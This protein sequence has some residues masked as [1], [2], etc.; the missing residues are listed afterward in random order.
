MWKLQ[1]SVLLYNAQNELENISCV[2][3]VSSCAFE[4]YLQE[5]QTHAGLQGSHLVNRQFCMRKKQTDTQILLGLASS[6]LR[7][8]IVKFELS[9]SCPG[10]SRLWAGLGHTWVAGVCD[11]T[12]G[13]PSRAPGPH[14]PLLVPPS[15]GSSQPVLSQDSDSVCG[16]PRNVV[17]L[18]GSRRQG[19]QTKG[20]IKLPLGSDI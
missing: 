4:C 18:G 11:R 10:M 9:T 16:I 15:L 17:S 8:H 20:R 12:R 5:L 3:C 1:Y 7:L 2:I 19:S 13:H 14:L 6:A